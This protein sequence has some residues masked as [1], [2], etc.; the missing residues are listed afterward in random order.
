M[1]LT[2][3]LILMLIWSAVVGS[4]YSNFLIFYSNFSETEN[5]NK[6]YYAS[7]S[8]IERAE[9]VLRQHQPWYEWSWWRK[10][11]SN[12]FY[13]DEKPGSNFS[14]LSN[15]SNKESSLFWN[16]KS[17]TNR[18][19]QEWNWDVDKMLSTWDSNNFNEMNYE[20]SEIVLLYYDNSTEN[21]YN[22]TDS[23]QK[24]TI[25]SI[26]TEI[27]LPWYI[28]EIFNDLDTGHNL[29]PWSDPNDPIVDRQIRWNYLI[30][31]T[32]NPFTIYAIQNWTNSNK[33]IISENHI[34]DRD[35]ITFSNNSRNPLPS[36]SPS[37]TPN[38]ISNSDQT[39]KDASEKFKTV[40]RDSPYS[41]V[42]LKFSLL[43]LLQSTHSWLI[44]PFLEYW[45]DFSTST[46]DPI[47]V[48]DKYY[49][50]EAVWNFWDYQINT[51]IYK[52]TITESILRSFTT[53]L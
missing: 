46:S 20:N 10:W 41:W 53:I 4:L 19:P 29:T 38:V 11:T 6:A 2:L 27:R 33:S 48:P 24:S 1:L 8:A 51:I 21:P 50:I 45:I 28:N 42:E 30:S 47:I 43:N 36:W 49:K 35:L 40:F 34:N 22:W 32:S 9:L 44:Y 37:S 3:I 18:I 25:E 14:Y 5:Y 39:I 31:S 17:R 52:P 7:I 15:D 23:I 12:W 16:I 13:S 26:T